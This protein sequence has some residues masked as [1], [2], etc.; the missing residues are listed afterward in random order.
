MVALMI[1]FFISYFDLELKHF[2]VCSYDKAV[3][4]YYSM[5]KNDGVGQANQSGL[6][7]VM[8]VQSVIE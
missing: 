4:S 3:K 8:F 5:K 2:I 7:I 6:I 1:W